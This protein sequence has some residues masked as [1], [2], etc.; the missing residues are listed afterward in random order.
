M[1]IKIT[2]EALREYVRSM[3]SEQN[4]EEN[5]PVVAEVPLDNP[6]TPIIVDPQVV[7]SDLGPPV[8]D[9]AYVPES[10]DE[11]KN[12]VGKLL[13]DI[14]E[15]AVP[16]AY[17]IVKKTLENLYSVLRQRA[18]ITPLSTLK[19]HS[20]VER[21]LLLISEQYG[22]AYQMSD[23]TMRNEEVP[24]DIGTSRVR[25]AT[26]ADDRKV[27]SP[28]PKDAE[29]ESDR[30]QFDRF[31]EKKMEDMLALAKARYPKMLIGIN[32]WNEVDN[33][34]KPEQHLEIM[35]VYDAELEKKYPTLANAAGKDFEPPVKA[36]LVAAVEAFMKDVALKVPETKAKDIDLVD[37]KTDD[38]LASAAG[39]DLD[40]VDLKSKSAQDQSAKEAIR[41]EL[42]RMSVGTKAYYQGLINI[43][44]SP[45]GV[46]DKKLSKAL[47]VALKDYDEEESLPVSDADY[48]LFITYM[49]QDLRPDDKV[50]YRNNILNRA[51]EH[52]MSQAE[53]AGSKG[54]AERPHVNK[55][56]TLSNVMNAVAGIKER[57]DNS[58]VDRLE[59]LADIIN[60][61]LPKG[62]T[63]PS[64]SIRD[65]EPEEEVEEKP[66]VTKSPGGK[67]FR[68]Q[69]PQA[70]ISETMTPADAILRSS[71]VNP[72]L[73]RAL[74]LAKGIS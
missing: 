3:L 13:D 22:G 59:K 43:L 11:L 23:P 7:G 74:R 38:R 52:M 45:E 19:E 1:S 57:G 20:N 67:T 24:E 26:Y 40:L 29:V 25:S 36:T 69:K 8:A 54:R 62:K 56:S 6:D 2:E 12:S 41:R 21:L 42:F 37:D 71:A 39:R 51:A 53:F 58:E 35:D 68:R 33:V 70:D 63:V 17:K 47:D 66:E 60:K 55:E 32:A 48:F 10:V 72:D 46:S 34:L 73:D 27:S 44:K 50:N 61:M 30:S 16:T 31:F 64:I 65:G 5:P 49:N 14:P 4:E 18:E 28:E 9:P 15:S